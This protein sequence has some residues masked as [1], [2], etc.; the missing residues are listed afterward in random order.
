MSNILITGG[1]GFIGSNLAHKYVERGDNITLLSKTKNK[2]KNIEGIENN[3]KL[4]LKDIKDIS[5]EDVE[6]KDIIFHCASTVDNYNIQD[7]PYLDNEINCIGTI[8]L[9]EACRNYN[10]N[11]KIVYIS[12]FFVNGNLKKLPANEESKCEPLG[13][14]PATKLAAEYFCKIYHRIFGLKTVIAR[15]T[16]VFGVR[17]QRDNNKKAAFNRM[18]NTAV[19][20]GTIKLYDNGIIKRDYIYVDD[21]I[22]A[23]I[24]LSERGESER[25][26]Y[27][28]RGEGIKFKDMVDIIIKE[29]KGGDVE[30]IKVPKFHKAS[31]I[32]DFWCDNNLIKSLGWS[33]KIS[34]E[35]GVKR[36]VRE[37]KNE[38]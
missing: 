19:N 35:E 1:L 8:A 38:R 29:A 20:G 13:I 12:T 4:V 2:I 33:P 24:I 16:N 30:V 10:K 31:G 32:D 9:L 27:I 22:S 18:I 5:K 17:E 28:G 23:L 6:N 15:L 7:S 3:I 36:V 21:V 25:I 34:I 26:Y 14:Y 37:Y 11:A